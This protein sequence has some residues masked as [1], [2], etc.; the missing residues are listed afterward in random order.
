MSNYIS[1]I[2]IAILMRMNYLVT[3]C[4]VITEEGKK[5]V[6]NTINLRNHTYKLYL[7]IH[8]HILIIIY[9]NIEI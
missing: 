3:I 6:K 2:F 9:I 4:T 8:N 7:Y 5:I 1:Y